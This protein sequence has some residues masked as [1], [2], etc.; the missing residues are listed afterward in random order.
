MVLCVLFWFLLEYPADVLLV[1][2]YYY[3]Y[4]LGVGQGISVLG[5]GFYKEK[6]CLRTD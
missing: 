2:G 5:V 4:G 3:Y 1:W 6:I